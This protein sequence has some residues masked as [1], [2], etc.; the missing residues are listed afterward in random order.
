MKNN[1]ENIDILRS[2]T[3]DVEFLVKSEFKLYDHSIVI[4]PLGLC[5]FTYRL[6]TS[7]VPFY[8][9]GSSLAFTLWLWIMVLFKVHKIKVY[10]DNIIRFQCLIR[11]IDIEASRI[12]EVQDW[13]RFVRVKFEKGS[14]ILFPFIDKLGEFKSEIQSLN[15][16]LKVKDISNNFFDSKFALIITLIGMFLFFGV[17]IAVLFYRFTV[18]Q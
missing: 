10:E 5:Y 1:S 14:L 4:L 18:M 7:E 15:P 11:N 17:T 12:T 16:E 8:Y 9:A 2:D 3:R 6:F 13:L